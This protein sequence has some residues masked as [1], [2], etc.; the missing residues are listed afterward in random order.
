MGSVATAEDEQAGWGVNL[1]N[2]QVRSCGDG[3]K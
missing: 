3:L 2:L 1:D